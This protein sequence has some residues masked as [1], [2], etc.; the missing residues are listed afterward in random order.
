MA[1]YAV[2]CAVVLAASATT[3]FWPEPV[4]DLVIALFAL[5]Y[6]SI[7]TASDRSRDEDLVQLSVRNIVV[8]FGVVAISAFVAL[9]TTR[10]PAWR[11]LEDAGFTIALT[12]LILAIV[13][14]VNL[15]WA[16]DEVSDKARPLARFTGAE[17]EA[18]LRL[19]AATAK[20][21]LRL[22]V[23]SLPF[24]GVA[25]GEPRGVSPEEIGRLNRFRTT[26][27]DILGDVAATRLLRLL[28]EKSRTLPDRPDGRRPLDPP[29]MMVV[30][31]QCHRRAEVTVD[32]DELIA[33][34]TDDLRMTLFAKSVAAAGDDRGTLRYKGQIDEMNDNELIETINKL[35]GRNGGRPKQALRGLLE[36]GLEELRTAI[37]RDGSS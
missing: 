34:A 15:R 8:S 22:Y 3:G 26:V 14:L 33:L 25:P 13:H 4:I 17:Q 35:K 16:H 28:Y 31:V 30:R 10:S 37:L 27:S 6:V 9:T 2:V 24:R 7:L 12:F 1:L 32:R 20:R 23:T 36:D 21:T 29:P 5:V 19:L 18:L 11:A